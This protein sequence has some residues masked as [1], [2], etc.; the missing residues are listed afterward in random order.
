MRSRIVPR[1]EEEEERDGC[2]HAGEEGEV[3][4]ASSED[5]ATCRVLP[6]RVVPHAP[7]KR[8]RG[9][10]GRR[11]SWAV[12]LHRVYLIDVLRCPCG[13]R[14]TVLAAIHDPDSIRKV[15]EA[16]GLS[17]EVPVLPAARGPPAESAWWGA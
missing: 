6:R 3:S 16:M 4:A 2:R 13:G 8:R 15:L 9:G 17:S 10:R 11:Y 1:V 7:G 12:L 14:R 5:E